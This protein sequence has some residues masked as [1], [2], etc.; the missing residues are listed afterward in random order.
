MK[1][2][3]CLFS[4]LSMVLI[5]SCS[6]DDSTDVA[7]ETLLP[8][9]IVETTVENGKSGSLDFT[10]TYDGNKL[11]Q[12]SL[13]DASKFVY[14]YTGEVITKVEEFKSSEL[15]STDVYTYEAGKLVSK[16]TTSAFSSTPPQKLTFVY[17]ANGTVNANYSEII[18]RQE[19]KYDTTRLYTFA[20]GNIISTEF[21]DAVREKSTSTFDDKKNP[22]TNIT[23]AK[24]LLDL[25]DNFDFYSANNTVKNVTVETD[26]SGKVIGTVTVTNTNKYNAN[27]FATE[28]FSGDAKNS[29]KLEIAY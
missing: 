3:L 14:T 13:S 11:K 6:S 20:N 15:Q 29:F 7:S 5:S 22:F 21:I 1:K 27:N 28:I 9:K 25:D 4:A 16:L 17:N 18:N 19:V 8:K 23:G 12:I 2:I 10:F 24:L 26:A